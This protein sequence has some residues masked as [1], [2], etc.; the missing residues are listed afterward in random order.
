MAGYYQGKFKPKNPRKYRGNPTNIIFRSGWELKFMK[1]CDDNNS[2]IEWAS[3]EIVIP[4]KSPLDG[5]FHRYF[6]DF[7]LKIQT[8]DKITEKWIVEIKPS[9]QTKEPKKKKRIT[10]NYLYEVKTY[11]VNKYKW[12]Y[13]EKW[14]KKR[15][16]KFVIFTEKELNIQY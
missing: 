14:C 13:A 7:M 3:E 16:Y 5:R 11:A 1:F 10:K 8:K 9:R 12:D 2:V 15:G 4:Y 6:P